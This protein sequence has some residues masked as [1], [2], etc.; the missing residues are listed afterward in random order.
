[1]ETA[2]ASPSPSPSPHATKACLYTFNKFFAELVMFVKK[3]YPAL[4]TE[5]DRHY[6]VMEN[7]HV[8]RDNIDHFGKAVVENP[9]VMDALLALDVTSS[10]AMAQMSENSDVMRACPIRGV[11]LR[12]VRNAAAATH[13]D[14]ALRDFLQF[15]YMLCAF[16]AIHKNSALEA[17]DTPAVLERVLDSIGEIRRGGGSTLALSLLHTRMQSPTHLKKSRCASSR[18][19]A[20]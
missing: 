10:E 14:Q 19:V 13:D 16:Y 17:Q 3:R 20:R 15:V 2:A 9:S 18:S 12:D 1:M 6:Q 11:S 7:L 5:L 4:K 8:T